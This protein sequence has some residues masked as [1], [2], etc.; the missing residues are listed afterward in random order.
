ML[1]GAICKIEKNML[2]GAICKIENVP[3]IWFVNFIV[4][5]W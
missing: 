3:G 1:Q 5:T 2:Q 4:Y